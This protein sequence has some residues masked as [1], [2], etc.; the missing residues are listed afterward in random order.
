[1]IDDLVPVFVMQ[2]K[3]E[4]E[5]RLNEACRFG[6]SKQSQLFIAIIALVIFI[7]TIVSFISGHRLINQYRK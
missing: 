5:M 6:F 2:L 1:M 7:F 4:K 3:S